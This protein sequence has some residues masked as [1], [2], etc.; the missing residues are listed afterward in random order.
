MKRSTSER[1]KQRKQQNKDS[2]PLHNAL[3]KYSSLEGNKVE[4]RELEK[5]KADPLFSRTR[6]ICHFR[7]PSKAKRKKNIE[8]IEFKFQNG[9]NNPVGEQAL[10]RHNII[11]HSNPVS[12][13][14]RHRGP[15]STC[16]F[17]P[18]TKV[19]L[20]CRWTA[21]WPIKVWFPFHFTGEESTDTGP[22]KNYKSATPMFHSRFFTRTK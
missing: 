21:V 19:V 22:E 1:N 5:K 4:G 10:K 9:H 15:G 17:R 12:G 3:W 18:F 8:F 13:A 2:I 6:L 14:T 11:Q 20:C 16:K 7:P